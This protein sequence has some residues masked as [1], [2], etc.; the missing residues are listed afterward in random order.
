MRNKI[1]STSMVE[2]SL[3]TVPSAQVVDI[4][5]TGGNNMT[6]ATSMV[7]ASLDIVASGKA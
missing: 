1:A 4:D 6:S 2:A 7:G 3:E 5:S